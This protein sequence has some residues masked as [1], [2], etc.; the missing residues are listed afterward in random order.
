MAM[1]ARLEGALSASADC[2]AILAVEDEADMA[3]TS[4]E[5]E[6]SGEIIGLVTCT[7]DEVD[8]AL[9]KLDAG[10]YGICEECGQPISMERLRVLPSAALCVPC[11]RQEEWEDETLAGTHAARPPQ[12]FSLLQDADESVEPRSEHPTRRFA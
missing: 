9:E 12:P 2:S 11:K 10:T 5:R 4:M 7:L 3:E 8:R 6:M 1:R